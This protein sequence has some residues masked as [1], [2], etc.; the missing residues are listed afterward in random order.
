MNERSLIGLM[1]DVD[2]KLF[3]ERSGEAAKGLSGVR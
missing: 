1:S 3:E 2:L